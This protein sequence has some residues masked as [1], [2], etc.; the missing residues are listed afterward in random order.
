M[1][2][3][4]LLLKQRR[5]I[6]MQLDPSKDTAPRSLA[7]RIGPPLKRALSQ[8]TALKVD[9]SP[10]PK[11]AKIDAQAL[12]PGPSSNPS[13]GS[14][15]SASSKSGRA[16]QRGENA[17]RSRLG[18]TGRKAGGSIQKLTKGLPEPLLDEAYIKQKY[19]DVHVESS[20]LSGEWQ[21][22]PKSALANFMT[23]RLGHGPDYKVETG[24]LRGKMMTR[25]VCLLSFDSN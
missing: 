3:A 6:L 1:R 13:R 17:G 8:A 4:S 19:A 16:S 10:R 9:D 24:N 23:T 7:S 18:N 5:R 12:M 22:N 2:L 15:S 21:K 25:S 20:G 14:R 11:Q